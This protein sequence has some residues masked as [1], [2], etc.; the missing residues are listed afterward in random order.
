MNLDDLNRNQRSIIEAINKLEECSLSELLKEIEIPKRTLIDNLNKLI[1]LQLIK[2]TGSRTQPFYQKIIIPEYL[3]KSITV[4]KESKKMGYLRFGSEGYTFEYYKG[5]KKDKSDTLKDNE[6]SPFLFPEFENLIPESDRRDKLKTEFNTYEIA[7]LL[8]HLVNTHGAYDFIY[9]HKENKYK[10]DYSQRPFWIDIKNKILAENE[11]PNILEDFAVNISK[12]SLEAKTT[13]KDSHLSG[14]QNKIDINIDFNT[15]EIKK[16]NS[17][18]LYLM[19]PYNKDLSDYFKNHKKREQKL[20]YPFIS[21][22]EHLFMSFAKNELGF[23]VPYTAIIKGDK[24]F[25]YITKRYDRFEKFKYHQKDFSQIFGLDSDKKYDPTSEELFTKIEETFYTKE[26]K[27]KALS[28]YF[29]SSIMKHEDLHIKNIGALQIGS[30]KYIMTPLYDL[31]SLGIYNNECNS[32][33]L[34]MTS[35]RKYTKLKIEDFEALA[36]ILKISKEDFRKEA[37][38]I[39]S[40]FIEEFPKYIENTKK[41]LKY[42]SLIVKTSRQR[43]TNFIIRLASFYNETLKDLK[44]N[45]ILSELKI[46]NKYKDRFKSENSIKYNN[47]EL[48]KLAKKS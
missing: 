19:K 7:E 36:D 8:T 28:F 24:D 1:S 48:K 14:Y 15:N 6:S 32:L 34:S 37:K 27:L 45:R 20:Y 2:K 43:E 5:Y 31:I 13:G 44:R 30:N 17:E 10:A 29:F 41:L 22:N 4:F 26:E 47:N 3:P 16:A 23:D 38:R 42:D 33:G 39:T 35:Q 18:A 9:S 21:I 25:H 40:I 46:E 11:Y 12:E